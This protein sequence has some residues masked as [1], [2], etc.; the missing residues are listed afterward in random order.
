MKLELGAAVIICKDF[1]KMNKFYQ[2]VL[3]QEIEADYGNC[4]G[5]K[6]KIS[7]WK[8]TEEYPIAK[9]L[10]YTFSEKGNANFELSFETEE[11]EELIQH[12]S[13][14]NINYLHKTKEE[15]WGQRT[16]RLYDPENNLVE[17]GESIPCFVKRF[18]NQGMT[19]E[20]VA[21]RTSVPITFV[22]TICL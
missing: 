2:E 1:D 3:L 21:Q 18:Y 12:L 4:I 13:Q 22:S 5:F 14:K 6:S 8:L 19:V 16:L 10:G 17:I 15:V 9:K 7:L 11:Y 20:E